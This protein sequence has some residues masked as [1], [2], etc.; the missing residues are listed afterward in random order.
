MKEILN[1]ILELFDDLVSAIVPASMMLLILVF[2]ATFGKWAALLFL[3]AFML[4]IYLRRFRKPKTFYFVALCN[5]INGSQICSTSLDMIELD[6]ERA[7][8]YFIEVYKASECTI[9]FYKE[10]K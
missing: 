3:L 5:S 7:R 4:N 10:K 1:F 8:S 6:L 2:G 9:I